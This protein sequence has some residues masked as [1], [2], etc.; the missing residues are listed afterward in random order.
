MDLVV[1]SAD[2]DLA[3]NELAKEITEYAED[4]YADFALWSAAPNKKTLSSVERNPE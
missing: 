2:L 3:K 1:N 4:F